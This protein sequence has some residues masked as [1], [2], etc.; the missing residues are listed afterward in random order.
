MAPLFHGPVSVGA[1][2][3]APTSERN[4]LAGNKNAALL[5]GAAFSIHDPL[6]QASRS[7]PPLSATT[8]FFANTQ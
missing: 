5:S 7:T 2:S 3:F 4:P 8:G 6:H 1:N